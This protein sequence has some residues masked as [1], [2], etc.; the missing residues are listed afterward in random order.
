MR[1]RETVLGFLVNKVPSCP[2]VLPGVL[3][4]LLLMT[5]S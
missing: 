3:V 2:R 5:L 4:M 1:V